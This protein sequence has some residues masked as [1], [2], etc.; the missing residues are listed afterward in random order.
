MQ[1]SIIRKPR[2]NLCHCRF[3]SARD[4]ENIQTSRCYCSTASAVTSLTITTP[5]ITDTALCSL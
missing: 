5:T 2:G 1:I 3:I 4:I